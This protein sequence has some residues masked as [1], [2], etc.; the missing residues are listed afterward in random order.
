MK[1][2]AKLALGV[3]AVLVVLGLFLLPVVPIAV[4]CGEHL[5]TL[6]FGCLR[7]S[8]SAS[9]MYAYFGV[10]AVQLPFSH[11]Y[12]FTYGNSGNMCGSGMQRMS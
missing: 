6:S 11:S 12:C 2:A 4:S 5:S 3:A 7:F 10:G 8:A 1:R 9:V